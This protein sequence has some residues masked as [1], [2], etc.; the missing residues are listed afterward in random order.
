[1]NFLV[2]A[3]EFESKVAEI[4]TDIINFSILHSQVST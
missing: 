4:N 2:S 1:M 3:Y